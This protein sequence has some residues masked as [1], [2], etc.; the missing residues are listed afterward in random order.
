VSLAP[1]SVI[2]AAA[3]TMFDAKLW[4]FFRY[5]PILRA[6]EC[7]LPMVDFK[8]EMILQTIKVP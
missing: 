5:F 2:A 7:R 1:K 4:T 8:L 3:A 6:I